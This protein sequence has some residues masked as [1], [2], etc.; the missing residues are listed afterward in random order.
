MNTTGECAPIPDAGRFDVFLCSGGAGVDAL[1]MAL[2]AGGMRVFRD[3]DID[4]FDST[5]ALAGSRVLLAHCPRDPPP[6]LAARLTTA[7]VAALRHGDPAD[8]VLTIGGPGPVKPFCRD[9]VTLPDLVRR[10]RRKVAATHGPLGPGRRPPAGFAGRHPALWS[11]HKGLEERV[12]LLHGLPGVG[13]TA[14]AERYAWLFRDAF[15]G[16]VLRTGPFGHLEP[17]DFL[18]GFHLD[19]AR[20]A[21]ARLGTD[22]SGLCLGRLRRLLADRITTAG[23]KVLV[24][25]D[26][27]PAGLP[28]A[29]LDRVAL[30]AEPVHTL[31]TSRFTQS[32]TAA[33]VDLP[34]LT[35]EESEGLFPAASDVVRRFALR[36]D[37][38]PMTL[39]ATAFAVRS[40][41][42]A[43]T[44][45]VLAERPDMA[46]EAI[47]DVLCEVGP[48]ARDLLRLGAVLAPAPVP[49]EVAR[50]ALGVSGPELEAGVAELVAHG[51]AERTDGSVRLQGLA[52]EV[53]REEF[54][55]L[56]GAAPEAVLAELARDERC[57]P[58]E[59]A[60]ETS[61][62][63]TRHPD[64]PRA[65]A[66]SALIPHAR[67]LADHA[68]THRLR[69]LRPVAAAYELHG[70]PT[71][72]GEIHAAILATGEATSADFTAAARVEIACGLD[73]EATS[74][75]REALALATTGPE[76]HE[77]ALTAARALD[78]QGHYA[79]ADRIFWQAAGTPA[80]GDERYRA[81]ALRLR[82]RPQEAIKLSDGLEQARSL[83]QAG[84]P[85]EAR[86]VAAA[87][88]ESHRAGGRE[89]HPRN[90]EAELVHAEAV[91]TLDLAGLAGHEGAELRAL[92]KG[93]RLRYGAEHPLTLT[94]AAFAD[95]ALLALGRPRHALAALAETERVV[96]RVLGD[97]HALGYRIR[98]G[99]GLAHARL[100][101]FGRQAEIV[102][103]ILGP[104]IRLLG[105]THPETLESQLDLGLALALS[106]RGPLERATALVDDAARDAVGVSGELLAKATAAKQVVRLPA[107]FTSAL[108]AVERLV[109][110]GA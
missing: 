106:G 86:D 64:R 40:I 83:L 5:T 51:F 12:L 97:G 34:G 47:R 107:S 16:G 26:D 33:A 48:V 44:D 6:G 30:A 108:F 23:E 41:P 7:F 43:V 39:R 56:V 37:G 15:P 67:A 63:S 59:P 84:H 14:L 109:W 85:R 69:L 81:V 27:V 55:G 46:P 49:R 75:A 72:A 1:E 25:V 57:N 62:G 94:A 98:H 91:L 79:E 54:G 35:P 42:G 61:S 66:P 96:L 18:P 70:D 65:A 110:P 88:V 95:R 2:R 92:A 60:H 90:A 20:A 36:C 19:L 17:D 31:V 73:A 3:P 8:R 74:H 29:V 102:E 9:P 24:L 105:R 99:M 93:Y 89:Q 45:E 76:R 68:P 58:A 80:A 100:R 22:V 87:V 38:H 11:V 82:G 28:P 32:W 52:M 77:A 101:E 13:K 104:Q 50:A 53:A 78:G 4:D 71:T 21:A 10:V 103:G